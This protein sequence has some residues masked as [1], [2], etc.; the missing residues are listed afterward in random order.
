MDFPAKP[1]KKKFV[2]NLRAERQRRR[3]ERTEKELEQKRN[4]AALVL[5]KWWLNR[6]RRRKAAEQCWSLWRQEQAQTTSPT[7]EHCL[8]IVGWYC[9]LCRK[10]GQDTDND[11]AGVCT[12]LRTKFRS[13]NTTSSSDAMLTYHS[14]L[15]DARYRAR[16]INYLKYII[17][18]CLESVCRTSDSQS[19]NRIGPELN[20]LL[21]YLNPKTYQCKQFLSSQHL[22]DNHQELLQKAAQNVTQRGLLEFSTRASLT[23]HIQLQFKLEKRVARYQSAEDNKAIKAGRL[24]LTTMTRLCVF[25]LEFAA[26][27]EEKM[28]ALEYFVLNILAA[29]LI[30][31][32]INDMLAEHVR[33][34]CQAH[35]VVLFL[36]RQNPE[37]LHKL[38][39]NGGLFVLGNLT[40]LLSRNQ[41]FCQPQTIAA[42]AD[43][44]LEYAQQQ[45]SDRQTQEFS[46]YHPLFKWSRAS[47]G[48]EIDADVFSKIVS[49]LEYL[50][51]F[52]FVNTALAD[53]ITFDAGKV[54]KEAGAPKSSNGLNKLKLTAKKQ[55]QEQT[56]T[57][58][59]S[60]YASMAELSMDIESVFSMYSRLSAMFSNQKKEI[61]HRIAFTPRLMPQLWR[62]MNFFGPQGQ[63]IIYMNAAER[64]DG[65]VDK[66]PLI[67]ILRMF[68]EACSLAFL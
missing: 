32:A 38:D 42:V 28:K 61:L 52:A 16:A 64:Q 46:Q 59:S 30:T 58:A 65:E 19:V 56:V 18:K 40:T 21:Q 20:T 50:W 60:D 55:S 1:Q 17:R 45:F 54:A 37:L 34:I 67:K 6:V 12:Y 23:T 57:N 47:W 49:Q 39:G 4:N 10:R 31:I 63:M 27:N 35:D 22:L 14:L 66:E 9:L 33:K 53:V 26:T 25:P 43:N 5:Q 15:V 11:L 13:D 36:Q 44:L 62:V 41:D 3:D 8:Y 68:C 2:D 48:N 7:I 29:P 51:S 24:W